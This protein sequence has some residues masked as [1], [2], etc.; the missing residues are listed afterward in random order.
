MNVVGELGG[1]G[2]LQHGWELEVKTE[3][4]RGALNA[5]GEHPKNCQL[6]NAVLETHGVCLWTDGTNRKQKNSAQPLALPSNKAQPP[7]NYPPPA[8]TDAPRSDLL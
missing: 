3:G 6:A 7:P 2:L 5:G 1:G 8:T 4:H